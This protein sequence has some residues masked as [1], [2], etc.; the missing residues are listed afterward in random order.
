MARQRIFSQKAKYRNCIATTLETLLSA[1]RLFN[2][3]IVVNEKTRNLQ[4]HLRNCLKYK[5]KTLIKFI[6]QWNI[7]EQKLFTKPVRSRVPSQ[8]DLISAPICRKKSIKNDLGITLIPK[9]IKKIFIR[10]YLKKK[11]KR[12]LQVFKEYHWRCEEIRKVNEKNKWQIESMNRKIEEYPKKPKMPAL[13]T[14]ISTEEYF[15]LI[16]EAQKHR[17]DWEA[18]I[19]IEKGIYKK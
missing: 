16:N 3:I 14:F 7:S 9:G 13:C 4:K 6:K 2:L 18:L 19:A 12:F 1:S 15:E 5:Q 8:K 11:F 17:I 10:N